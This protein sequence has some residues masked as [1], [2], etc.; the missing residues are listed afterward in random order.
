[1]SAAASRPSAIRQM[2]SGEACRQLT[3]RDGH[4]P[5]GHPGQ[6]QRAEQVDGERDQDGR[7]VAEQLAQHKQRV[8]LAEVGV[9]EQDPAHHSCPATSAKRATVTP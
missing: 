8:V 7:T 1:M 5:P 3:V 6:P 9:A 4:R 2:I